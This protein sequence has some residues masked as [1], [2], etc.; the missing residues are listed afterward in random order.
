MIYIGRNKFIQ[1]K[2]SYK[3]GKSSKQEDKIKKK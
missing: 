1:D 2:Y 3:W